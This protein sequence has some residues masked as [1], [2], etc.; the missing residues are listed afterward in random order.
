MFNNMGM[1][2]FD[3]AVLKRFQFTENRIKYFRKKHIMKAIISVSSKM[4]NLWKLS[5]T[6]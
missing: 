4:R 3:M 1:N 2:F 5:I 6:I